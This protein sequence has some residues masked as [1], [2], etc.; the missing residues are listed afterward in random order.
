MSLKPRGGNA[1]FRCLAESS[2]YPINAFPS[3][4]FSVNKGIWRFLFIW[5]SKPLGS[6]CS[7]I[8]CCVGRIFTHLACRKQA[9]HSGFRNANCGFWIIFA[10]DLWI[11]VLTHLHPAR[12]WSCENVSWE[13]VGPGWCQMCW[14]FGFFVVFTSQGRWN[15]VS[16]HEMWMFPKIGGFPLK[17][18]IFVGFSIINNHPFWG[19]LIFGNTHV[20]GISAFRRTLWDW[21]TGV[22]C[23][24]HRGNPQR[25][26]EMTG[27]PMF[28]SQPSSEYFAKYAIRSWFIIHKIFWILFL[29][30][31]KKVLFLQWFSGTFS[32]NLKGF[33]YLEIH[34]IFIG[35]PMDYGRIHGR[36]KKATPQWLWGRTSGGARGQCLQ[37]GEQRMDAWSTVGLA[38][39][40]F[41]WCTPNLSCVC[42]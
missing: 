14:S 11:C 15:H 9:L 39:M 7:Y 20:L 18:F 41:F 5:F 22:R 24:T 17:S 16:S 32:W 26:R 33:C 2:W 19:T 23:K 13:F 30:T 25:W 10:K 29:L 34:P 8:D 21:D 6:L 12:H 1:V 40:V 35:C 31:W 28:P 38:W 3:A 4:I 42:L 36:K 37:C 27:P